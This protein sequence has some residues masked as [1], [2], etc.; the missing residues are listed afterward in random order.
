MA[1]LEAELR[2]WGSRV[3]E[4]LELGIGKALE[5]VDSAH[6]ARAYEDYG[7]Q[8]HFQMTERKSPATSNSTAGQE[9]WRSECKIKTFSGQTKCKVV[10]L[11]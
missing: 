6:G 4:V 1:T 11:H 2:L 10:E 7:T 3:S 8:E 5:C 9:S